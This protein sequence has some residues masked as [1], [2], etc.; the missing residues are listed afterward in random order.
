MHNKEMIQVIHYS[1]LT[2]PFFLG[3]AWYTEQ[4]AITMIENCSSNRT[5]PQNAVRI[6]R[7]LIDSNSL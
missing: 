2:R 6:S 1:L 3:L 4:S 7:G 5:A